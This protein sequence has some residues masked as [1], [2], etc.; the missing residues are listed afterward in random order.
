MCE[1]H[2]THRTMCGRRPHIHKRHSPMLPRLRRDIFLHRPRPT[3][4]DSSISRA[5]EKLHNHYSNLYNGATTEF[6]TP[7]D[8]RP[9]LEFAEVH[10][11]E[12]IYP[13]SFLTS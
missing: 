7:T 10:Y 9:P 8:I 5:T 2:Y 11:R 4:P 6:I 13:H 12:N 3:G 1:S